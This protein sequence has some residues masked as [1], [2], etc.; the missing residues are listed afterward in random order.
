MKRKNLSLFLQ[1]LSVGLL[2]STLVFSQAATG[3]EAEMILLRA[4]VID[5]KGKPVE[6]LKAEQFVVKEDGVEQEIKYFSDRKESASVLIMM[7]VSGSIDRFI[8][9]TYAE[10]ALKFIQNN[11]EHEYSLLA[12]NNKI[13]ELADWGSGSNHRQQ[14]T[15]SINKMSET[16]KS[17]GNTAFFD[18]VLFALEKFKNSRHEKKILLVFS[19]GYDNDSKKTFSALEKELKKSNV[20]VFTVAALPGDSTGAQILMAMPLLEEIDR[21]S[22]GKAFYPQNKTEMEGVMQLIGLIVKTQY[23]IGYI[24]K[25]PQKDRNWHKLEIRVSAVNEKGKNL[26]T[27]IIARAGYSAEK[28]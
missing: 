22:G 8:R 3:D 27:S 7:D 11:S 28:Q 16:K 19:D 12:F 25:K 20:S 23:V 4:S 18:A 5:K 24:P 15:D 21:I 17:A 13:E 6:N 1:I 2:A 10:H 26:K 14:I 9:E